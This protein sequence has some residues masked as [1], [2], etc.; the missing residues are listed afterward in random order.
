LNPESAANSVAR[1]L[2]AAARLGLPGCEQDAIVDL[3]PD[4]ASEL[5]ARARFDHLTGLLGHAVHAGA[6]QFAESRSADILEQSWRSELTTCVQLEQVALSVAESFGEA[7]VRW[8]LTKGPA[9]AHL[10]Y[11]DPSQRTFGDFDAVIHPA[12]WDRAVGALEHARYR[13][14]STPLTGD[15][16]RRYGKG[17]TFR[18][19][20][21]HEVDLHMRF[22]IGRFAVQSRPEELFDRSEPLILAGRTMPALAEPDRLLHACYHAVLGGFRRLRA[23]RDVAQL[24]L[25]K[26]ADW[27]AAFTVARGWKGEAVVA[28]AVVETWRRLGL[29]AIHPAYEAGRRFAIPAGDARAIRVFQATSGFGERVMTALPVLPRRQVPRFVWSLARHRITERRRP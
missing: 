19:P 7:E 21:G 26:Q 28:T 15:Y 6:I 24:L 18:S 2:V 11:P 25:V 9:L 27:R 1:A 16:D 12:D 3:P 23:F 8:R 4:Y 14:D 5:V 29:D 17:A 10:D 13:R 22:A 20:A